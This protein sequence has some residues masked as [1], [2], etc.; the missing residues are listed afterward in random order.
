M[1]LRLPRYIAYRPSADNRYSLFIHNA[2]VD[3]WVLAPAAYAQTRAYR[4]SS[5]SPYDAAE[6]R[7]RRPVGVVSP[8]QRPRRPDVLDRCPS[9]P[10]SV[11]LR[12]PYRP[13]CPA[14]L[15]PFHLSHLT[16]LAELDSSP[17]RAI[18]AFS[19]LTLLVGREE[20]HPTCKKLS[21][22][23]LAWLSVWSEVQT[24]V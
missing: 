22:G 16:A 19:A 2:S 15:G 18:L 5:S 24:C 10:Q 7:D 23:V 17:Y 8:W 1:R 3:A 20:G 21:S 13:V 14:E 9:W 4:K 6:H 11:R 12:L